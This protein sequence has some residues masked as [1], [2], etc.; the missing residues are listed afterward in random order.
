MSPSREPQP[1]AGFFRAQATSSSRNVALKFLDRFEGLVANELTLSFVPAPEQRLWR[2]LTRRRYPLMRNRSQLHNRLESLLEEAHIQLSS[3]VTDL[4]GVSATAHA[5][6]ACGGKPTPQ[7]WRP[8]PIGGYAPR[9]SSCATR[10][11]PAPSSIRST[12]GW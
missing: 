1:F 9:R 6:S 3:L 10:W 5:R 8:W 12:A 2:T 7:L 4:L 11:V